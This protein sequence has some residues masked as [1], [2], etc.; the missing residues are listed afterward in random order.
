MSGGVGLSWLMDLPPQYYRPASGLWFV[1]EVSASFSP[2]Q[3][4]EGH[5]SLHPPPLPYLFSSVHSP[6]L[7]FHPAIKLLHGPLSSWTLLPYFFVIFYPHSR[8]HFS[9]PTLHNH[10][11]VF[12]V[13]LFLLLPN[14]GY[15]F[16][17]MHFFN[18]K[19]Y[20][21]D[22]HTVKLFGFFFFFFWCIGL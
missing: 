7:P 8:F 12:Y 11:D 1:L 9:T 4:L 2:V 16:T 13:Y 5:V 17:Y 21:L 3:V 10:S 14:G 6:F 20:F 18:F 19:F 15:C 22:E